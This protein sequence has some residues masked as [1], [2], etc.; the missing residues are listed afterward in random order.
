MITM[1][2]KSGQT[3]L[4]GVGAD[5]QPMWPPTIS[6]KYAVWLTATEPSPGTQVLWVYTYDFASGRRVQRT[7]FD[8]IWS[9]P[10]VSGST[11]V[12]A[13]S[14]GAGPAANVIS[15]ED[16]ATGKQFVVTSTAESGSGP[17]TLGEPVIAGDLVAWSP[18]TPGD[19]A[20]PQITVKN[21]STGHM[22]TIVPFKAAPDMQFDGWALSGRAV[23]WLQSALQKD[24][25]GQTSL[26]STAMIAESV[27]TGVR[28]VVT[29][30]R[31]L[32]TFRGEWALDGDLLVWAVSDIHGMKTRVMG[33]H[34]SGGQPFLIDTIEQSNVQYLLVSGNT[35]AMLLSDNENTSWIETMQATQ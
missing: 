11:M 25:S 7:G 5:K 13:K 17:G 20:P 31:Y 18:V 27:D 14:T 35:V 4:L 29:S 21:L 15:G 10:A 34:L 32:P 16:L 6:D 24:Q 22:R 28:R 19:T 23:V 3:K 30:G 26:A 2:L 12:W 33:L 1:D 8:G 9:S